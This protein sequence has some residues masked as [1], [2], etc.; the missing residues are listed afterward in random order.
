[1]MGRYLS[2]ALTFVTLP[3]TI[4]RSHAWTVGLLRAEQPFRQA[5]R[6][7]H[8]LWS[9][10]PLFHYSE[11]SL[12]RRTFDTVTTGIPVNSSNVRGII[13]SF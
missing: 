13:P 5:G 2:E 1:M 6:P 12:K 9:T 11:L 7:Q 8:A 10:N 3:V 4:A